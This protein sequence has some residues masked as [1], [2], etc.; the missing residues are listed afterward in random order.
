MLSVDGQ[1]ASN[2]SGGILT[3]RQ[4]GLPLDGGWFVN[5]DLGVIGSLA[6]SLMQRASRVYV[7][8]Y[9]LEGLQPNGPIRAGA[10][11]CRPPAGN[12]GGWTAASLDASSAFRGR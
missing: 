10:C 8:S 7:P 2:P 9:L 12:P 3:L 5:N 1:L 4:R 6:P 11:N